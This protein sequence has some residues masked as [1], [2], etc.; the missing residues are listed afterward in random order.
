MIK[1]VFKKTKKRYVQATITVALIKCWSIPLSSLIV[2]LDDEM[3]SHFED[4]DDF[5]IVLDFDN[6]KG[7]FNLYIQY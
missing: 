6:Q 2:R 7:C 3:V 1:N 4:E 5:L